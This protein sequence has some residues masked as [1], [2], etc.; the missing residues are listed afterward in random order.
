MAT[1]NYQAAKEAGYSDKEIQQYLDQRK[2]QGVDLSVLRKTSGDTD[3]AFISLF[4]GAAKG[5]GSTIKGIGDLGARGLS[6]ITPKSLRGNQIQ[7]AGE[8]KSPIKESTF[9]PTNTAEK[10]G[11]GAEQ[12]GE[13]FVPG[14]VGTKLAK[15]VQGTPKAAKTLGF[16]ARSAGGAGTFGGVTALQEGAVN[17]K[18]GQAAIGGAIAEGLVA[19]ALEKTIKFIGKKIPERFFSTFFKTS[20]DDLTQKLRTTSLQKIQQEN[21]QLLNALKKRGIVKIANG[22]IEVN[23][24]LAHEALAHGFGTKKTGYSLEKMAEYSLAKQYELENAARTLVGETSKIGK[25]GTV[26]TTSKLTPDKFWINLGN[27]KDA[28][29]NLLKDINAEFSKQGYG[30]KGFLQGETQSVGRLLN[31]LKKTKG[32]KIP[33]DTALELRRLIDNLRNTSSFRLNTNLTSK[34]QSFKEAANYL[35]GKLAEIPELKNI[36]NE[37][38]FYINAVDDLIAEAARRG[39]TRIISLFDAVV[40][41][42]SIGAGLP[43]AGLGL[44]AAAR[45]IQT[46]AVLTFLGQQLSKLPR[47]LPAAQRSAGPIISDI[48]RSINT[49]K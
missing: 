13:L 46:P 48:T 16:L 25:T 9:T 43:G 22:K 33:P 35:R 18:V 42:S 7:G 47:F 28:Y 26:N 5:F 3:N 14:A 11:F 38:R 29:I 41:G 4:R 2:S 37:Y 23:P 31:V 10:I 44:L 6:A 30:G 32:N 27:K 39:N 20:A 34:Q 40:G 15:V 21:P 12:L 36:M 49:K 8:Y 19:P 17:K 1:F 45:T 24:T